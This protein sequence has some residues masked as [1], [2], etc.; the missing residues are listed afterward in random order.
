MQKTKIAIVTSRLLRYNRITSSVQ[1]VLDNLDPARY[2]ATLLYIDELITDARLKWEIEEAAK[3]PRFVP[4]EQTE[5]HLVV[6]EVMQLG[7]LKLKELKEKFAAAI[8]LICNDYGEDGKVLG[9]LD[10]AG[11]PYL[12]AG[13]LSS[14]ICFHKRITKI[15]LAAAGLQVPVDAV[16][17]LDWPIEESVQVVEE[18]LGGFP[19]MLKDASSGASYGVWRVE[20]AE[21]LREKVAELKPRPEREYILEEVITGEEFTVGVVGEGES[22][23][24]LPPVLIRTNNKFFDYNAKY[25]AG[26]A[27]EIVPAPVSQE[28]EEQ[29]KQTALK[30]FRA[31]NG[32]Y[33]ARIDM[34][35]RDDG[36]LSVLEINSIPGMGPNSL[37]PKE[38]AAE[39]MTMAE[40]IEGFV[41]K[42]VGK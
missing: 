33:M 34:I 32:K 37:F 24:A 22:V 16:L 10:V 2:E 9:L 18:Q 1:Y 35:R 8:V 3:D 39:G 38:L 42:E 40:V 12:S 4:F 29:L 30:A 19:V 5:Q 28:I 26:M 7:E 13:V 27:E 17:R 21:D 11:L 41:K 31:V 23:R 15:V 14:A 20:S 36:V 6:T 25:V